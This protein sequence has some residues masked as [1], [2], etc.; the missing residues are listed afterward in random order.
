MKVS[1]VIVNYKHPHIIEVCLRTLQIT[2]GD[3]EV[4][5]V[6]NGSGPETVAKLEEF[7]A[8]GWIDKL[9]LSPTNGFFAGGNNLG[10]AN[11]DPDSDV[12][13]LLNSD[14]GFLK[15]EW[16]QKA[17]SWLEGTMVATPTIWTFY[18]TVP[19]PGPFDILSVG[20]SH[21]A[22]ID[23]NARPEGWC[24]FIRREHWTDISTDFPH[25]YGFEEMVANAVRNGARCGVLF[26]YAP[27]LI[28][29]EQGSGKANTIVNKRQPD[30]PG[31][32]RGIKIETLDFTLGPH[33]HQSYMNW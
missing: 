22:T 12:I 7:K 16:M 20:W 15:P 26:N 21:D 25:H 19:A 23:G 4:I 9:V 31:W 14:V 10:V 11:A 33:E 29:A 24:C 18:P 1:I 6:D 3:Y 28:H 8:N 32:F 2:E 17:L 27:Y 30:M 13:L 5:V